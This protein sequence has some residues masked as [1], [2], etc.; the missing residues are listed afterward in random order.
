MNFSP[1]TIE[2]K[3]PLGPVAMKNEV[4][5][6][7]VMPLK[8]GVNAV[9]LS[10]ADVCE[11]EQLRDWARSRSQEM[12]LVIGE[13]TLSVVM[14]KLETEKAA[15]SKELGAMKKMYWETVRCKRMMNREQ[16]LF[17]TLYVLRELQERLQNPASSDNTN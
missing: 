11:A 14:D 1:M 15:L 2:N 4:E 5:P 12:V 10:A 7:H 13:P 17:T 6:F 8:N 16:E 9:Y 3:Q